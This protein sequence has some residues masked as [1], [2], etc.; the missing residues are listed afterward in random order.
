M[1]K[2]ENRKKKEKLKKLEES[3]AFLKTEGNTLLSVFNS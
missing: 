1:S 3:Y 2:R